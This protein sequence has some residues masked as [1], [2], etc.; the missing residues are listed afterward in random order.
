MVG[1]RNMIEPWFLGNSAS[2][3]KQDSS[4]AFGRLRLLLLPLLLSDFLLQYINEFFRPG[5]IMLGSFEKEIPGS[6]GP[7]DL[8][9]RERGSILC[10]ALDPM[11]D[12]CVGVILPSS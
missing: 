11:N 2:D 9:E 1:F 7:D 8:L 5:D 6:R 4:N 12:R 3:R 10:T